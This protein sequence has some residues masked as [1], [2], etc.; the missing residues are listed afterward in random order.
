MVLL[1][2][3]GIFKCLLLLEAFSGM[4]SVHQATYRRI[5]GPLVHCCLQKVL[6]VVTLSQYLFAV[7]EKTRKEL[8][9][10]KFTGI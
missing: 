10:D 2:N 9:D 6:K 8:H 4:L 1:I 7:T 5:L 3:C